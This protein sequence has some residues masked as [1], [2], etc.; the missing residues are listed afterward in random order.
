MERCKFQRSFVD[1]MELQEMDGSENNS[2]AENISRKRRKK[3]ILDTTQ[4]TSTFFGFKKVLV[5]RLTWCSLYPVTV[6]SESI[7]LCA[8]SFSRLA[9]RY[10]NQSVGATSCQLVGLLG[11]PD[12]TTPTSKIFTWGILQY[13]PWHGRLDGQWWS[14]TP[15]EAFGR[16]TTSGD[17]VLLLEHTRTRSRGVY[18]LSKMQQS[19]GTTEARES[20]HF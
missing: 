18:I 15:Q 8:L 14:Q 16:Q 1:D 13:S 20:G 2:A 9:S 11:P 6:K 19:S 3:T 5:F 12:W 4:R 7:S 17:I 10:Q